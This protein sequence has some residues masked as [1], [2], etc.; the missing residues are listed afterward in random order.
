MKKILIL[1]ISC[2]PLLCNA[3]DITKDSKIL[4]NGS[5]NSKIV[6]K[7]ENTYITLS[8]GNR[9]TITSDEYI[10]SIYII[11]EKESVTGTIFN[12]T[13]KILI[14]NNNFLHEFVDIKKPSKSIE[15]IYDDN[16]KIG[17]IYVL[18]EGEIPDYVEI[19]EPSLTNADLLLLSTHSDDEQL[20]FAGLMPH[21]IDKGA[22]IQVVY[23]TNHNNN[24]KR[25]HEQ[26]HGLY[27]VGIR[28]YPIIGFI[29]DAYST[30]LNDAIKNL[31][32]AEL[33]EEDAILFEVQMIRK[34]KPLVIVGHD[35]LGEYSHGQHI[36]NTYVLKKAILL[37][38]DEKYDINTI[39]KYGLWDTPKTYL[40]LYKENKIVMDYD[41]PLEYFNGKTAYEVSKEGYSK[42]L[43]Q[44]YTWFTKW[45]TGV[46]SE[47]IG[48]PYTKATQIKKYSPCEYGLYRSTVGD[49]IN[50]NDMF[51]NLS[52]RKD[53]KDI[54]SIDDTKKDKSINTDN[55]TI[56]IFIFSGVIIGVILMFILTRK[57]V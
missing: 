33:T 22:K 30:N 25:L 24:T 37:S 28:N 51:E 46:N 16:I 13:E 55:N 11:Y 38:N 54:D 7:N 52:F 40:H 4:I 5:I 17:E 32:K 2:F 31:E 26:L 50:K 15:L 45:L 8:K 49:D 43:T 42:H 57:K 39:N 41:I 9:I 21:Y 27:T 29:P 35:E 10:S 6:D 18:S 1:L 47:G 36:L 23:F 48:T 53:T 3:K 19:W 56:K 20:F 34:F 14:G 12:D 44:Q